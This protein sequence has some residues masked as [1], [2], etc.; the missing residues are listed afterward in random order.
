MNTAKDAER[1]VLAA[2]YPPC[3]IRGF[4]DQRANAWGIEFDEYAGTAN[5]KTTAIVMIES[6]E[7]VENIRHAE[8]GQSEKMSLI[9]A[10]RAQHHR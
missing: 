5:D 10:C 8:N 6:R 9:A 2:K 3:G 7:A 1:A 4:A